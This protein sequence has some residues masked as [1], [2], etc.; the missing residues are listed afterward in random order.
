[1]IRPPI[2]KDTADEIAD[3]D[4]ATT[5]IGI[6]TSAID[7]LLDIASN[8]RNFLSWAVRWPSNLSNLSKG[9]LAQGLFQTQLARSFEDA[10]D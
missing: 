7:H 4:S 3:T 5:R 9:H 10:K 1:M 6:L 8:E 2:L